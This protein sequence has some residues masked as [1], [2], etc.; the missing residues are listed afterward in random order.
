MKAAQE[1]TTE[2]TL[3]PAIAAIVAYLVMPRQYAE[4][5]ADSVLVLNTKCPSVIKRIDK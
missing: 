1:M 2:N 4:I 3:S 5:M